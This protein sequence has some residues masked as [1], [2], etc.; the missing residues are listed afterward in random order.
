[1]APTGAKG[2]DLRGKSR[3]TL[4][5]EVAEVASQEEMGVVPAGPGRGAGG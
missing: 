3:E 1:M 5:V 2:I 4:R